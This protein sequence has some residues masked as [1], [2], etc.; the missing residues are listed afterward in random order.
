M[1][2]FIFHLFGFNLLHRRLASNL[3]AEDDV[4]LCRNSKCAIPHQVNLSYTD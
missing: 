2:D 1:S 3:T 4:S